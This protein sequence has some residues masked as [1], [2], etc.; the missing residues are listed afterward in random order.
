[1]GNLQAVICLVKGAR[2]MCT[3]NGWKKAGVANGAQGAVYD[4]TYGGVQGP[5]NMPIAID[6]QFKTASKGGIYR[7]HSYVTILD[8]K[9]TRFR[10]DV[11]YATT[12]H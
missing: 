11:A 7:G 9:R 4:I 6:V 8:C 12:I 1:M 10:L 3:L 5:T 2:V